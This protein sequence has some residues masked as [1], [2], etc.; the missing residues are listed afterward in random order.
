MGSRLPS[1]LPS[2]SHHYSSSFASV[3][4]VPK[5]LRGED[6]GG[7]HR[8]ALSEVQD[9]QS[10]LSIQE[11]SM[12]AWVEIAQISG[13]VATWVANQKPENPEE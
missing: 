4:G 9:S 12:G 6:V 11:A 8:L 7:K 10:K 13:E 5:G 3:R 2:C 1:R